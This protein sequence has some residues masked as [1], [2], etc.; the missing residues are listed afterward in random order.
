MSTLTITSHPTEPQTAALAAWAAAIHFKEDM[1]SS[2]QGLQP[3]S[4][5]HTSAWGAQS[6]TFVFRKEI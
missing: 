3:P 2:T 6:I 4:S 5:F 1:K